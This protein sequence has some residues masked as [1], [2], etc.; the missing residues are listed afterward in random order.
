MAESAS[1][2]GSLRVRSYAAAAAVGGQRLRG[3][4][5]RDRLVPVVATGDRLLGGVAGVAAGLLYG[6]AVPGQRGF[7]SSGLRNR[8]FDPRRVYALLELGIGSLRNPGAVRGSADRTLVSGRTANGLAGLLFRGVIAG[9]CLLPPTLLMGCTFPAAARWVD[10]G[11]GAGN[12]GPR[13]ADFLARAA[14]QRQYLRRGGRMRLAGFY[15]LRVHDLAVATYAAAS[16][17]Y[18][19]ALLAFLLP[20]S[21]LPRE[22]REK[23]SRG[24]ERAAAA[25]ASARGGLD[26]PKHWVV[27]TGRAGRRGRLD[28]AAIAASGRHRL[29]FFDHSGGVSRSVC[30][31]AAAPGRSPCGASGTRGWRWPA[32]RF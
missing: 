6:R 19:A 25:G 1:V 8:R 10:L 29:H 7:P 24:S 9:L 23:R 26:L 17:N 32:A 20:A 18:A 30:G 11:R 4:D 31:P 12:S 21:W 22:S 13:G 16:I 5:L 28:A 14:L 15:L 2:R 3:F 27:G